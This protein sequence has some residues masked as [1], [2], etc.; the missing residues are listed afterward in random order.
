VTIFEQRYCMRPA[1]G[2][3]CGN[4]AIDI[5]D[6]GARFVPRNAGAAAKAAACALRQGVFDTASEL[7]L[8][9]QIAPEGMAASAIDSFE[10]A[11]QQQAALTIFKPADAG[12]A[13]SAL[14]EPDRK[15]IAAY[16]P[17]DRLIVAP[18]GSA[19]PGTG[20]LTIDPQ[21]GQVLGRR[22]GGR[23]EAMT[24]N[25]VLTNLI[26]M[27]VCM[28][29]PIWDAASGQ[30]KDTKGGLKIALAMTACIA[31][32]VVGYTPVLTNA[33]RADKLVLI[34]TIFG[35]VIAGGDKLLS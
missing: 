3:A 33:A 10:Q 11:R 8:L 22:D 32:M 12:R 2:H 5:M 9:K 16:E 13:A 20:W 17:K 21:T 27:H 15:W 26:A 23:G 25:Q 31:G 18:T 30:V 29:S 7:T 35:A 24:E 14:S 6:N 4:L 19:A 28:I 34:W 1:S